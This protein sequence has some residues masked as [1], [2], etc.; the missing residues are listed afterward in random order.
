M[1]LNTI[2]HHGIRLSSVGIGTWAIGGPYWTEDE[3]TGWGGPLDDDDS[4]AGLSLAL[5]GGLFH[6]DTAD[7]YGYGRSERLVRSAIM[8]SSKE[9][10]IASKVGFV[11]SSAPNVYTKENIRFQLEQS[12]RNLGRDQIEIYYIHHCDFGDNDQYLQ[13]ATAEI[14]KLKREGKI[15]S[16]GLSGYS[17]SDLI[18]VASILKPDFIQSW[19][20]IEHREFIHPDGHLAKFMSANDIKFIAMMPFGQGRILGK[21]NPNSPPQFEHGDNRIGNPE[22]QAESLKEF[23]PRINQLKERFG[24]SPDQLILPSLGFLL[25]HDVVASVVPGFR[26]SNQVKGI[27]KAAEKSFSTEDREFIERVFPI[28]EMGVHP[29]A[30]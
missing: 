28:G 12:L 1:L 24:A 23:E 4:V 15:K 9:I 8:N 18:R 11:G 19:A 26:N 17:A 16:I 14:L 7:V 29:W 3:P 5:Q 22:F 6:V 30:G 21:Y 13:E 2:E 10:T 25:D 27:L 20:S